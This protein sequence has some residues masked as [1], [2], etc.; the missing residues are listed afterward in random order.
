MSP[1]A[2]SK[3]CLHGVCFLSISGNGNKT[4]YGVTQHFLR[5]LMQCFPPLYIEKNKGNVR[6]GVIKLSAALE[7]EMNEKQSFV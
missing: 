6:C 3:T 1:Q 4:K 2:C 7:S 5:F